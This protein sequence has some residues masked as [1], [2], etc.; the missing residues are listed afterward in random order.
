MKRILLALSFILCLFTLTSCDEKPIDKIESYKIIVSLN[1]DGSLNMSYH[2]DWR[3]VEDAGEALTWVEIGIPNKHIKNIKYS[4][5]VKDAYYS[6]NEGDFMYCE[7]DRKYYEGDL[8]NISF[9]FTEIY[10]Y[11]FDEEYIY[12]EFV[13]GWFDEIMVDN[14]TIL[15]NQTDVIS[16]NTQNK[17]NGHYKWSYS[18]AYG[19]SIKVNV[20]YNISACPNLVKEGPKEDNTAT[21]IIIAIIAIAIVIFI[22]SIIAY[23]IS[24][25]SSYYTYRGF[26][27][28]RYYRSNRLWYHRYY[29]G[30]NRKGKTI[31]DPRI[32]NSKGGSSF[33]GGR[34]CA[35]ACAC[36]CAGGGRA[37][38]ARKDFYNPNLSIKK[39]VNVLKEDTDAKK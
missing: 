13:P 7:L 34:S 39:L 15:W 22:I 25:H 14:I 8:V 11:T 30:Y 2:I 9:S 10:M 32:V 3:I 37:G 17:E 27:G 31:K 28:S 20:K 24:R 33:G 19:E 35:C 1:D 6:D 4:G 38:C 16:A 29:H 36:A 18:L 12:Y 23:S 26:S 5:N 21:Y